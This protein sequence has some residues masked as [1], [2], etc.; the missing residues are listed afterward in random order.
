MPGTDA[1]STKVLIVMETIRIL[2]Y[3]DIAELDVEGSEKG[4]TEL[5]RFIDLKLNGIVKVDIQVRNRHRDYVHNLPSLLATRLTCGLLEN[6][7]ELWI[8]GFSQNNDPKF[9]LSDDEVKV[10]LDWMNKGGVMLTGDHSQHD[11]D[12][13]CPAGVGHEEF[14]ALGFTIGRR[15]P[16]AGQLRVWTGPPT[17]CGA[18]PQDSDTYN[19]QVSGTCNSDLE[20]TC[21]QEDENPQCLE[22]MPHPPHFLFTYKLDAQRQPVPIKKFPDHAHIGFVI[23]NPEPFDDNWPPRPPAPQVVAKGR[24]Q[25]F[26]A[27]PRVYNLVVAYDGDAAGVGRI[28]SDATFHHFVNINLRKIRERDVLKN[29]VPD[30][31]LDEIAQFYANLVIW[32]APRSLRDRIRQGLVFEAAKHLNVY[33]SIGRGPQELGRVAR[34][35]VESKLGAANLHRILENDGGAEERLFEDDLLTYAFTGQG[36]TERFLQLSPEEVLG[37]AVGAYYD[38]LR[39]S[40][41]TPLMLTENIVPPEAIFGALRARFA[42]RADVLAAQ[43]SQDGSPSPEAEETTEVSSGGPAEKSGGEGEGGSS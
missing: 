3:T 28:V 25:R 6:F 40:G 43:S 20:E 30:T 12:G 18:A 24:D 8:F 32:L 29:P 21:L 13:V 36:D 33:E 15:V 19:T 37:Q 27:D 9:M 7:D 10:L 39:G 41:F 14:R 4:A 34:E 38:H 16:R 23:D 5:K 11:S 2:F 1:G 42:E 17:N 31:P 35:A 26:P 22:P